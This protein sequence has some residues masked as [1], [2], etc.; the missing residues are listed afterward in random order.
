MQAVLDYGNEAA[1]YYIA[2]SLLLANAVFRGC[3]VEAELVVSSSS[4]NRRICGVWV[5]VYLFVL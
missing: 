1:I 4:P 5:N 2:Y 3:F